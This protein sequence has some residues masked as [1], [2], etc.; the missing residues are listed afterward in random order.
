MDAGRV[1]RLYLK[2]AK[3]LYWLACKYTDD[4]H[5]A[6]DAVHQT[7]EKLLRMDD[8]Q[9]EDNDRMIAGLLRVMVRQAIYEQQ[10]QKRKI[11]GEQIIDDDENWVEVGDELTNLLEHIMEQDFLCNLQNSLSWLNEIYSVPI[12]MRFV[13]DMN[14]EEIAQKLGVPKSQVSL[15][16]HRGLIKIRDYIEKGGEL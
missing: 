14:N 3:K 2:Y 11:V 15:H 13:Y 7:F 16:I 12:E 9:V 5:L 8:S 4:M 10:L 1:E 6:E